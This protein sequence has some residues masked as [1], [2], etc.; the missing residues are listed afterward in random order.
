MSDSNKKD[1]R[2]SEEF[3]ELFSLSDDRIRD[4]LRSKKEKPADSKKSKSADTDDSIFHEDEYQE[5]LKTPAFSGIKNWWL[6]KKE[7]TTLFG[8]GKP[9]GF[10]NSALKMATADFKEKTTAIES[11]YEESQIGKQLSESDQEKLK[12]ERD[13]ELL[14]AK[15]DF[16]YSLP[17]NYRNWFKRKKV[18]QS[19]VSTPESWGFEEARYWG[20]RSGLTRNERLIV[21]ITVFLGISLGVFWFLKVI[22]FEEP[23]KPQEM[24]QQEEILSNKKETGNLDSLARAKMQ[25]EIDRKN[26]E[27][28]RQ[29][30]LRRDNQTINNMN[31][32]FYITSGTNMD[33]EIA[34][35]MRLYHSNVYKIPLPASAITKEALLKTRSVI[36]SKN[37]G[38]V[39]S[40]D[41][42]GTA[43][44]WKSG[45]R[46]SCSWED[47]NTGLLVYYRKLSRNR[48]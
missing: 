29:A 43:I 21:R 6:A 9:F 22:V 48:R 10:D 26:A 46:I 32:G 38:V 25:E 35:L 30:S 41:S 7:S 36:A 18:F 45:R 33:S 27:L 28:E 15:R 14:V 4:Y 31:S 42:H 8:L 3:D 13:Y 39:S 1:P 12:E 24:T 5:L 11:K 37:P 47:V 19:F 20:G 40:R 16:V 44:R 23:E 2:K 17:P 34:Y